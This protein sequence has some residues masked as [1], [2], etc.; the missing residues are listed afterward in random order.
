MRLLW[1]D[2]GG[3]PWSQGDGFSLLQDRGHELV[4]ATN[5]TEARLYLD[6][7]KFDVVVASLDLKGMADLLAEARM[8]RKKGAPRLIA[9]SATLGK[10]DF[11]EH[12]K[13]PG[14]AHRYAKTPMPAQGFLKLLDELSLPTAPS[15]L[16][17]PKKEREL[18][19]GDVEVLRKYLAIKEDEAEELRAERDELRRDYDR[20]LSE[21]KKAQHQLRER[22]HEAREAG[23]R[24]EAAEGV[25]KELEQTLE[26]DRRKA[27]SDVE[28]RD[29]RIQQLEKDAEHATQ[30]YDELRER[31]RKDLLRIRANERDLEAKLE[32]MRKDSATLIEARDRHVL[33][34]QRKIDALEYDLDQVQD[35]RVQAE[36]E[37]E[38]YLAKLSKVA[39]ALHVAIGM[40]E[41][42]IDQERFL[43]EMEGEVVEELELRDS[44]RAAQAPAG[45]TAAPILS[46]IEPTRVMSESSAEPSS[47]PSPEPMD[48]SPASL[49]GS[50]GFVPMP[51]A[52][53][54]AADSAPP[55]D[56]DAL[57]NDGEPTRVVTAEELAAARED[58]PNKASGA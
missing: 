2:S 42:E 44:E 14:A 12:S 7:Q 46:S 39:R 6:S 8:A 36:M 26:E 28:G 53:G 27:R 57:A 23:Q 51:G 4:R 55:P 11:Q 32:L 58:D 24:A 52:E 22:E 30:K 37:S 19:T 40:I 45:A 5:I 15:S 9:V 29:A 16:P 48:A 3:S 38:R 17:S 54:I 33:D 35:S 34:M 21:V 41:S 18:A 20:M 13:S 1:I 50:K 31:V 49:M 43:D 56:L 10:N 47:D 25:K